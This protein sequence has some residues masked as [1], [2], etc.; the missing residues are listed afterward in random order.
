MEGVFFLFFFLLRFLVL[1][2][3]YGV[4]RSVLLCN[5][6]GMGELNEKR[7]GGHAIS[8]LSICQAVPKEGR[9]RE[10]RQGHERTLYSYLSTG[11]PFG[12]FLRSSSALGMS[13]LCL[14]THTHVVHW[15]E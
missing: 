9:E 15:W 13:S 1:L 12:L 10:A 4:V 5:N 2:Y 8:S 7:G 11:F 6:P 3:I 14:S